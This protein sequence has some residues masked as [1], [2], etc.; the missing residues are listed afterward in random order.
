[1]T[2]SITPSSRFLART[3]VENLNLRAPDTVLEY[4][5]G[6]GV[7]TEFVLRELRPGAKFAAIELNPR[8]ADIFRT[9]YPFVTLFQDSVSNVEGICKS[10]GIRSVD[11]I[12][13][14]LPW[15]L[16]PRSL[17]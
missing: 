17:Q 9:R 7:L 5:P 15:A 2:A 3:I 12:V 10:A 11:C 1:M 6:T 13:S 4:G 14:G 8:F 16:F